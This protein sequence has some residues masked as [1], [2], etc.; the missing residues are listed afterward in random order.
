MRL[1]N[2][3]TQARNSRSCTATPPLP[4]YR[5]LPQPSDLIERR[6]KSLLSPLSLM[7]ICWSATGAVALLTLMRLD[8]LPLVQTFMQREGLTTSTFGIVGLSWLLLALFVYAVGD[9]AAQIT[10]PGRRPTGATADLNAL[11]RLTFAA[12]L[13]LLG[14]TA[15]WILV[16]AQKAGG[17]IQLAAAVYV[18]SLGARALLLEN[19]LF[20]GM[21]LFYAA[22]PATACLAA[23]L[24]ATGTLRRRA[25]RLMWVI[26]LV[27]TA[28]LFI[29]PIV[30][31][32]RLLLLQLLL[33]AYIAACIVKRRIF[34]LKWL[35]LAIGLFFA[36]WVTRE[37]ITNPTMADG[38]LIVAT[39]K[40]GFYVIN[41]MWNAFAPLTSEIPHT[42][43]GLT[44]EGLMFFT[45]TD[46]YFAQVLA[47]KMAALDSVLGGGEF[48][49]LTAPFVD[50]GPFGGAA[51][52]ALSA[53]VIRLLYTRAPRSIPATAI[54]AQFGAAL[55]FSSHS[56]YFTNQNFL[57]SLLLIGA[58]SALGKYVSTPRQAPVE[59]PT[60]P[61]SLM[62]HMA[63][64]ATSRPKKPRFT[65]RRTEPAKTTREP[66]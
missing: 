26:L 19:K 54:Y 34:G 63:V 28:A 22:L 40:L 29:L 25:C 35:T 53:F 47:P 16:A 56:L 45:L 41:D 30:M 65:T 66:A 17:L 2:L 4:R 59:S 10:R 39:Q 42:Y 5:Q 60:L 58:I 55:L 23:A 6:M 44:L 21:R 8:D 51:F 20:T 14:V 7:L 43:G 62:R 52:I 31:S 13:V 12:N 46:S 15:L 50:F 1:R 36:L 64:F 18:D 3:L 27:N 49:F 9:L 57:F 11:A 38:P 32:Q 48:P 37:A 61:D 24:L 33:S